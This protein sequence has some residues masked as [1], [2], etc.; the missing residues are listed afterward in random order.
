MEIL[1]EFGFQVGN[2]SSYLESRHQILFHAWIPGGK[3]FSMPRIYS[4]KL[5][6]MPGFQVGNIFPCL[7]SIVPNFIPCLD[8]RWEI[9]L[10]AQNLQCQI[11]NRM[12]LESWRLIAFLTQTPN[13]EESFQAWNEFSFPK[14]IV[15]L[16][17]TISS[18]FTN[19]KG[20]ILGLS[21]KKFKLLF[22]FGSTS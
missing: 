22:S 7:E 5:Y 2:I 10:H 12:Y 20:A 18:K 13:G 21:G 17:L 15:R 3:Y 4:A 16:K 6:S 1:Q 11:S 9:F 8:S 14:K 19:I